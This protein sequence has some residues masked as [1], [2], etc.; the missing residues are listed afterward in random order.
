MLCTLMHK[1]L[2]V[3]YSRA[4]SMWTWATQA[5]ADLLPGSAEAHVS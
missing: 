3:V 4:D 1:A 5:R 2:L